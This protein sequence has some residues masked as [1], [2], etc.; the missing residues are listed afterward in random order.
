M[1]FLALVLCC[2]A[3]V[4]ASAQRIVFAH[5]MLANQ[6]YA[7]GDAESEQ[8][9]ASYQREIREAQAV[10][11]DGFALNAGG[12]LKEPRY[13]RRASE[14]FEAAY[15]LH[16]NFKLMFSADMC[17]QNDAVDVEDMVRRFANSERY[18]ALYFKWNGR[19][20]LTTFA[21]DKLGSGFWKKLRSDL[22]TGSHPSE[23]DA[24]AALPFVSG[25]PSSAP[26]QLFLVPAFFWG[27]ELP[28]ADDVRTGVSQY[29]HV[30]DGAFYWGIAGVPALGHSP[31]QIP[32]SE[33]Y[34]DVL[35][36]S[37][38]LY[39]APICFQ[40]WGANAGRSYE[41]GGFAGL[42]AMWMNAIQKT[43]PE[44]VEIITWNDFIEGTYVSPI[45]DPA[46]YTR[47]N[48][49]GS[50]VEPQSTLNFF[51]SHGGATKLLAFYIQWY[52]TG[53]EPPI[54]DDSV[55]WAYRTRMRSSSAR[56][57][58]TVKVFGPL[59]NMVYITANL[60]AP[61]VLR[62]TFGEQSTSLLLPAG[63]TDVEVP[64]VA[65]PAPRFELTRGSSHI[66]N[67]VGDDPIS[68]QGTYPN[69]YYSTGSMHD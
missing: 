67:G 52:K 50:S 66:A 65:G 17:C 14:M 18:S 57:N 48:D 15:R 3:S 61:A 30:I 55:Y 39:M 35:H 25:K 49:L 1:S 58:G 7:P 9:I 45:D 62:V 22:E 12:W 38:K 21:G 16:S 31:D 4:T 69:F 56:D 51:H 33:A 46:K 59:A 60:A 6:D 23:N 54:V 26:I 41:Y 36:R 53:V 44:W 63:S 8:V 64:E 2:A 28:R 20:V 42:R 13:I 47:A 24:P 37:G 10:G 34:A 32:S 19:F 5:Y 29:A 68:A 11:I 40:F 27:G 43:H